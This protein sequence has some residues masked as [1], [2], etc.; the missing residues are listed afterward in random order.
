MSKFNEW[1]R[2]IYRLSTR[3]F[4]AFFCTQTIISILI[5]LSMSISSLN[6]QAQEPEQKCRNEI[7]E[8]LRIAIVVGRYAV[9]N[10]SLIKGIKDSKEENEW[11]SKITILPPY[12]YDPNDGFQV[13]TNI[14]ECDE[15]DI[16]IGPSESGLFS[17]LYYFL[18]LEQNPIPIISPIVT[19]QIGNEAD[20]WF[21]R[22]NVDA[23]ERAEAMYDFLSTKDIDNFAML[24]SDELFGEVAQNAFR[25][26]LSEPQQENFNSFRFNDPGDA[27]EWLIKVKQDRPE[28]LGIIGSRSEVKQIH[29]LF[30]RLKSG[31]N[32]YNPFIFTLVDIRTLNIQ[33]I[34]FLTVGLADKEQKHQEQ[35]QDLGELSLLAYDTTSLILEIADGMLGDGMLPTRNN[36]AVQFR[37]RLIGKMSGAPSSTPRKSGMDLINRKNDAHPKVMLVT[38]VNDGKPVVEKAPKLEMHSAKR[39]A[40]NWLEIRER[41]YGIAPIVNMFLVAL[42]V[43]VLTLVDLRKTHRV[44]GRDFFR[45]Q[46]VLLVSFNV[47]VALIVFIFAAENDLTNW[48]SLIGAILVGFGYSAILKTTLFETQAGVSIGFKRYYDGLVVWIYDNIRR[49]Q[50]EKVGPL[51]NYI[52]FANSRHNLKTTLIESYGFAGGTQRQ[53]DLES[54]LQQA[55]DKETTTIGKRKV[56]AKELLDEVSWAKLQ[57]RRIVPRSAKKSNIKDPTPII[58]QSVEYCYAN[59]VH[60]LDELAKCVK[61][62]LDNGRGSVLKDEFQEEI[63]RST[64]PRSK[65]ATCIRWLILLDGFSL[66]SM[67]KNGL[68]PAS[69]RLNTKKSWFSQLLGKH[70]NHLERRASPRINIDPMGVELIIQD[71]KYAAKFCDLSEGG[72]RIKLKEEL[73]EDS[74]HLI[75]VKTLEGGPITLN[76]S[77]IEV[78]N[79][80]TDESNTVFIGVNWSRLSRQNRSSLNIFLRKIFEVQRKA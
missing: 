52:I 11:N 16:I 61:D 56:L 63:E 2:I 59:D 68:L 42:I 22:T 13:F 75:A 79:I 48:S 30:N 6:A 29:A 3:Q 10:D 74:S 12:E 4:V 47:A 49:K 32:D 5:T 36:W 1:C 24:Y 23:K 35:Q 51:V 21:F 62:S 44:K 40:L 71:K 14:V 41:R 45:F 72:A 33:D 38:A 53:E 76:D 46:F 43:A 31:W 39:A 19:T 60:T 58:D 66:N 54:N 70:H 25:E 37:K 27:R 77:Q 15:A 80:Y 69:F 20:N 17:N 78:K 34:Y 7:S 73:P 18:D 67:I 28:A 9:G 50:F 57:D 26:V 8:G 64:T 65:M 55:L